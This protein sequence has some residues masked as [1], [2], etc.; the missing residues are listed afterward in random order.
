[1]RLTALTLAISLSAP[2]VARA[3]DTPPYH[4]SDGRAVTV[5]DTFQECDACPEMKSFSDAFREGVLLPARRP[6]ASPAPDAPPP[7]P[8]AGAAAVDGPAP[9]A[10]A[11]ALAAGAAAPPRT[12]CRSGMENSRDEGARDGPEAAAGEVRSPAT[13]GA[14][15]H[16]A[17][18][19]LCK[20]PLNRP[21]LPEGRGPGGAQPPAAS[22]LPPCARSRGATCPSRS[23]DVGAVGSEPR[24]LLLMT[25]P[26]G[27][28]RSR[29]LWRGPAACAGG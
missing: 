15:I 20:A 14:W 2:A 21:A 28:G 8:A 26:G 12:G 19:N 29:R 13:R 17:A 4:L 22:R 11:A 23:N 1:M 10:D 16:A 9:A 6:A 7:E 3:E 24:A 18:A 25:D 27:V 5:L